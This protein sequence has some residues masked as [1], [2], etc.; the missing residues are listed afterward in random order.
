MR[1]TSSDP[2]EEEEDEEDDTV[3]GENDADTVVAE[4]R[5]KRPDAWTRPPDAWA[6][7]SCLEYQEITLFSGVIMIGIKQC[8]TNEGENNKYI[9]IIMWMNRNIF[10][11]ENIQIF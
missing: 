6:R 5:D 1:P 4:I 7:V 3:F 8:M 2:E 10:P 11:R 9:D